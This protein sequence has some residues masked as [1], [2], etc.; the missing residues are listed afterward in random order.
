FQFMER[1]NGLANQE[2]T[3]GRAADGHD[4]RLLPEHEV[5]SELLS[6][7]TER[8][9]DGSD[10]TDVWP[11]RRGLRG[12]DEVRLPRDAGGPEVRGAFD[13]MRQRIPGKFVPGRIED[14][15]RWNPMADRLAR[16]RQLAV[17]KEEAVVVPVG[18]ALQES[19]GD[20]QIS[21]VVPVP[22]PHRVE[23]SILRLPIGCGRHRERIEAVRNHEIEG[24]RT[25]EEEQVQV[26]AAFHDG[27]REGHRSSR[28]TE[29]LGVD[30]EVSAEF[31]HR[32]DSLSASPKTFGWDV[33]AAG[34][35]PIFRA[36]RRA[37]YGRGYIAGGS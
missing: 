7:C 23:D 11:V 36:P 17:R 25:R 4:D 21:A 10:A 34:E 16:G 9:D 5:L 26:L 3:D 20:P 2:F 28:M 33:G 13:Q 27:A 32:S 35:R 18:L 30:R 31:L 19:M 24:R 12:E 1:A 37:G 22:P 15:G 14:Q 6:G 29:S 8:A